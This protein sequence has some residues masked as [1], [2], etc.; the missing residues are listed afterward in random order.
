MVDLF[1][2]RVAPIPASYA[3]EKEK[4]KYEIPIIERSIF[5]KVIQ[6]EFPDLR[7]RNINGLSTIDDF[8]NKIEKEI[9]NK[10]A[11]FNKALDIIRRITGHPE[12]TLDSVLYEEFKPH[13]RF[14]NQRFSKEA[15]YF[16]KCQKVYN[17]LS[18]NMYSK[19]MYH[20][21]AAELERTKNLRELIDVYYR[22]GHF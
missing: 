17:T 16:L 10:E 2:E 9:Q 7:Y 18:E 15:N 21:S 8:A 20:P 11:F 14:G 6:E 12:Y 22:K 1:E 4:A 13:T 5:K 19:V 3:D